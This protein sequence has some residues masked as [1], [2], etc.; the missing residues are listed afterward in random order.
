[1]PSIWSVGVELLNYAM[2]FGFVARSRRAALL[3]AVFAALYHGWSIWR[4]DDLAARYF[5]FYA[6]LLPFALGALVYFDTTSR[7][8]KSVRT[9][10]ILCAPAGLVVVVAALLGGARQTPLFEMLF[11]CNLV[12]QCLA[13]WALSLMAP[14]GHGRMDKWWGDLSYPIFL[15]HWQVGYMLTFLLPSRSLGFQLVLATLPASMLVSYFACR[16]QDAIVEPIRDAIRTTAF[17]EPRARSRTV[18]ET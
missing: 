7:K 13:V 12:A 3:A 16:Y 17:S 5:P 10:I 11:Y 6:A 18:V 2:L 9:S 14:T 4:G 15:C 8:R 1:V